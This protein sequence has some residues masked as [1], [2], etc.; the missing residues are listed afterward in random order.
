MARHLLMR[1]AARVEATGG[2]HPPECWAAE[3][4]SEAVLWLAT[5]LSARV[6]GI[7]IPVGGGHLLTPGVNSDP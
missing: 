4:S 5:D 2:L 3:V 1:S 7:H 6:T